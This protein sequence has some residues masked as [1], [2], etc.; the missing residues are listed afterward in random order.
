MVPTK[1]HGI[2]LPNRVSNLSLANPVMGVQ[3]PSAIYPEST[4]SPET[5]S[6]NPT[7]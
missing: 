4:Q 6:D 3:I 1:Y 2:L 7:T 5:E